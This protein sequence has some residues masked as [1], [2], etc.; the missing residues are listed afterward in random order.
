MC[1]IQILLPTV[2]LKVLKVI[3]SGHNLNHLMD[4][5][6]NLIFTFGNPRGKESHCNHPFNNTNISFMCM[7]V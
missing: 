6:A 5:K 3:M 2:L 7:N 4:K 1:E